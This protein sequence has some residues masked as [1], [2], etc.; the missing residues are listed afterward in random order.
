[1]L[2]LSHFLLQDIVAFS[3]MQASPQ[4]CQTQII[5]MVKASGR[6][7][8]T[9]DYCGTFVAAAGTIVQDVGTATTQITLCMITHEPD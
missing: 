3:H 8:Y 5:L 6:V 7:S 1:M 4:P 9:R 2:Q